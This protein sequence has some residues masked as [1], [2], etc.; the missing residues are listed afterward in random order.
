MPPD[1]ALCFPPV[2]P[3][4]CPSVAPLKSLG[5]QLLPEFSS[6]YFETLHI[7]YKH[8]EDVHANFADKKKIFFDKIMSFST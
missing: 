1:D 6:N 3:S 2:R 4:V 5:N 7:Y 8:F